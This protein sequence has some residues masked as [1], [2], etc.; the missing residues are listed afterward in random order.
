MPESAT[1]RLRRLAEELEESGLRAEGTDAVHEM[2]W[3]RSTSPCARP[4]TSDACA[5]SGT[6]LEPKSDPATWA[7]GTQLD[8]TRA[9]LGEQPLPAARRYA[10]G[11][12]S[13]L[14][15]H[16]DRRNEWM[17]FD[18]PAGSERDLVVL[19]DV[20]GAT[21]VQRHPAGSVRVVGGFGVL[22]WQGFR[23]H[24]EPPVSSWIDTVTAGSAHGDAEVLEAMLEFAVHDLGSMGIG[25]LLIYRPDADP[26]PPVEERLPTPP[27]LQVRRPFHLAPLRH[28]L[29]QVDGAAIFDA[30][31][32]CAG[33]GS[34][35]CRAR[36]P[37]R[38]SRRSA[39]LVT[40]RAA[41]TAATTH[42]PPSSP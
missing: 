20:L 10:D 37:R 35:W 21:I 26:G 22:R 40:R 15:R 14:L 39:V 19:A 3:R 36:R 28:A 18:R 25:A 1:G 29:A 41:A 16:T 7:S 24:H 13:W 4:S 5:S 32:T 2:L 6:I 30:D 31:G 12:S 27:P 17:V 42:W 8:I 33:S 11:L 38:P 9:P 34:G 23:W